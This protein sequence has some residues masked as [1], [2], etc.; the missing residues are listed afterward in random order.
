MFSEENSPASRQACSVAAAQEPD[1]TEGPTRRR[2]FS[3]SLKAWAYGA[4]V[5]IG[6][7]AELELVEVSMGWTKS[8]GI[9]EYGGY[10]WNH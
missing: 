8:Q 10:Q 6:I 9:W 3:L 5:H 4:P 1:G 2:G 7:D